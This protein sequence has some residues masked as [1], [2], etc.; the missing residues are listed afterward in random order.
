MHILGSGITGLLLGY[1]TKSPVY[2]EVLGGQLSGLPKGPRILDLDSNTLK[3]LKDLGIEEQPQLFNVGYRKGGLISRKVTAYD[4]ES[5][6]RKTRGTDSPV[7]ASAMSGN[8]TSIIGW[9]LN[10]IGLVDRLVDEVTFIPSRVESI[11]FI[12]NTISLINTVTKDY[13][14]LPIDECINTINLNRILRLV[15]QNNREIFY[16]YKDSRGT[17]HK[18][19]RDITEL[20]LSAHDTTFIDITTD[21]GISLHLIPPEYSYVYYLDEDVPINRI[22]RVGEDR[23]CIECRG[24]RFSETIDWIEKRLLVP[25][26]LETIR[27]CQLEHSQNILEIG[28]D[29][30]GYQGQRLK[31][32]GRFARWT[33]EFKINSVFKEA[34]EYLKMF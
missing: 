9:D 25:G 4:R 34:E 17:I 8:K 21:S 13:I 19:V 15:E 11:D 20:D 24:D 23:F 29:R 26:L 27:F 3:L 1:L 6:Y 16:L 30:P 22:T 14:K 2:G 10:K 32:C 18:S 5:Y 31:L 28:L 7:P 33:H 12:S